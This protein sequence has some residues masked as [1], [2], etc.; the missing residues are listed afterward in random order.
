MKL[1]KREKITIEAENELRGIILNWG[2]TYKLT[3]VE[4]LQIL[5]SIVSTKL[6]YAL[7]EERH[8]NCNKPAG[9]E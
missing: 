1:H 5:N 9:L 4:T 7:R 6:K 2:D 8:G 3:L